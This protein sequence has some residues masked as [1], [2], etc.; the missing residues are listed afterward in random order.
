MW[1]TDA[2]FA[3]FVS[4]DPRMPEH[5]QLFIHRVERDEKA[6]SDYEAEV[7]DF[8]LGVDQMVERLMKKAA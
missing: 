2:D 5:L 4:F 7:V 1:A 3:D 8:L 6:I